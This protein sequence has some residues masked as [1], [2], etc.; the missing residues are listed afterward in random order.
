[1][2]RLRPAVA[3]VASSPAVVVG[4]PVVLEGTCTAPGAFA[5]RAAPAAPGGP[6]GYVVRAQAPEGAPPP[7]PPTEA[8]I[9]GPGDDRYNCGVATTPPPP[10]A[11]PFWDGCKHLFTGFPWVGGTAT[12][13]A[14]GRALFQSDHCFDG[15]ISPVTNPFL[16]EDP[17]ALT[18]VRPIFIYQQ[19]PDENY[20]FRGGAIEFFGLQARLALTDRWSFVLN[21]LGYVHVQIN[22]GPQ[23]PDAS[24][25][26]EISLGPKFTFLRNDCSGTLGA[27]GLNFRIPAGTTK[28]FQ[29]TGSLSLVPYLSM[30]QNFCRTSWGSFNA[31]GTVGYSFATDNERTDYF[32][33]SLHLDFDVANARIFYPLIELNWFHYT[34]GGTAN[35][36]GFEGADL[37]NIGSAHVSGHDLLSLA[38]GARYKFN[39]CIQAGFAAEFPISG[40]RDLLDYRL[41]FDMI[42]RY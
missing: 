16:F 31:L 39:E 4:R 30:G 22:D 37:A 11:H 18:E 23:Y 27:V 25:I 12:Q 41:T 35:N 7:P 8:G 10:G 40:R 28:T 29:G 15:F 5:D 19:A 36:L 14:G 34:E 9:P 33:T 13:P 6:P 1:M 42:F 24:S 38:V 21:E 20:I 2:V 32:Y 17:R 3:D 26:S